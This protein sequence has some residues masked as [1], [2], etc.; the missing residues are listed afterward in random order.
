MSTEILVITGPESSGKTTLATQLANYWK[1]PLVTEASRDYLNGKDS[2]QQHDLLKIAKQQH[3]QEQM[4]LS[5]LPEKIICDTDLLV[6]MIWSEV[7][8][9][10]CDPWIYSTFENSIKKNNFSR[11]Y[12]LCDSNIPWQADPLRENPHNRDELFDLYLQKLK[13]YELDYRIVKGEPRQRL[14]LVLDGSDS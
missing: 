12:Y 10:H 8:Y 3:K 1:T 2:Y 6:I 7:R 14:Q 9:G 13:E 11:H 5:Y 4:V